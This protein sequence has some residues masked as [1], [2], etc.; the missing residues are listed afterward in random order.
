LLSLVGANVLIVLPVG[1]GDFAKGEV[2]EEVV[3]EEIRG[4]DLAA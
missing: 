2:V 1:R 4:G 3:A